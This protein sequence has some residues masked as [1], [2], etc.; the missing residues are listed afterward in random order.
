MKPL[1][2][3]A[4]TL[5]QWEIVAAILQKHIPNKAIWIFGSRAKHQAKPFSDLDIAII[6]ETPL[7]INLLAAMTEDFTE[8]ALPFK[9]DLVDWASVSA[10][11]RGIIESHKVVMEF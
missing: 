4:I 9:V 2:D 5:E 10:A 11:F 6:G 1:P 7:S 3:I 8:S